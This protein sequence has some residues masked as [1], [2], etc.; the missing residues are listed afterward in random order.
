MC[1]V[2]RKKISKR[3]TEKKPIYNVIRMTNCWNDN[4]FLPRSSC[5]FFWRFINFFSLRHKQFHSVYANAR[6]VRFRTLDDNSKSN[7]IFLP[8]LVQKRFQF[9]LSL[10][11]C[12]GNLRECHC[13]LC[14]RLLSPNLSSLLV[15][16][17]VCLRHLASPLLS[18]ILLNSHKSLRYFNTLIWLASRIAPFAHMH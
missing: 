15:P 7:C 2:E 5:F 16:S 4:K 18:W 10:H 12:L 13:N 14:F 9:C 6:L 11:L 8:P 17:R 1:K 3:K